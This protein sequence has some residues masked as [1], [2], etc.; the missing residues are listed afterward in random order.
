MTTSND[1]TAQRVR[2]LL[3]Y[4]PE[5]GLLTW[6]VTR[7]K[8]RVGAVAGHV[9]DDY[10][11]LGI[12]GRS[13]LAHRLAWLHAYGSLP[14]HQIDHRDGDTYNNRLVNLRDVTGSVNQQNKKHARA[15]N[16]TGLLGVT[17]VKNGWYRATI[18]AGG[19]QRHLGRFRA[20][21]DAHQAYLAAKRQLHAGNTL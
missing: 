3:D 14:V 18:K 8:A 9:R 2:E 1:L 16:K 17:S 12:D 7:G 15:D 4:D 5:T 13:H 20:E 6:R 10:I 11:V 19:K 21:Q